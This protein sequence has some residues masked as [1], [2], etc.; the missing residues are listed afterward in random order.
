M[1]AG[2]VKANLPSGRRPPPSPSS[3]TPRPNPDHLPLPMLG[4]SCHRLLLSGCEVRTL[5]VALAQVL[6]T[7]QGVLR[8]EE[9]LPRSPK[10]R[11]NARACQRCQAAKVRSWT[12]QVSAISLTPPRSAVSPDKTAKGPANA[13][14]TTGAPVPSTPADNSLHPPA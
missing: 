12:P 5:L 14:W 13:V 7:M 3:R 1:G 10:R 2:G 4:K 9:P 8:F 6:A 11:K